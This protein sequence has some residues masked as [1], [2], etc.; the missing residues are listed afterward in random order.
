[1]CAK[2]ISGAAWHNLTVQLLSFPCFVMEKGH[3]PEK[4]EQ[5]LPT[6]NND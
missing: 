6:Q 1:M 3:W 2:W 5:T 4:V